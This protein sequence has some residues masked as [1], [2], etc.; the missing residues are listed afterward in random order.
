MANLSIASIG[1]LLQ[2]EGLDTISK[3]VRTSPAKV[4]KVLSL[5]IPTLIAGMKKNV[6]TPEGDASLS[7][8]LGD[9]SGKNTEAVGD[10]LR[11]V[12]TKDGKKILAHVLGDRQEETTRELSRATGLSVSTIVK[13]LALV[14]PLLLSLLGKQQSQ[15]AQAAQPVQNAASP[16]QLLTTPAQQTPAQ[17]SGLGSLLGGL[18]GGGQ[19]AQ[20]AQQSSALNPA[21]LLLGALTSGLTSNQSAAPAQEDQ[22]SSLLSGFLNLFR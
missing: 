19:A 17:S 7:R 21:S 15:A 10:F 20:P 22:S 6:S 8:A 1:Q 4:A 13:I 11:D 3:K 2:G 5:G 12:D 16:L 14:A 18:L 9:H